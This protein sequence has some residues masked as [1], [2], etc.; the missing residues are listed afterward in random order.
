MEQLDSNYSYGGIAV[1][2]KNYIRE[3]D[4]H[5]YNENYYQKLDVDP[6]LHNVSATKSFYKLTVHVRE[7]W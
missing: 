4:W 2:P 1:S 7:D 3:A 6:T 5:L